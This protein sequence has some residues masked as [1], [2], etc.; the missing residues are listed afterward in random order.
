MIEVFLAGEGRNEL[1]GWCTGYLSS[2][3][4]RLRRGPWG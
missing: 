3:P 4:T 1:G 2:A